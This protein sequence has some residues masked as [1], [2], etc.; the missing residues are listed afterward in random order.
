M[1]QQFIGSLLLLLG[2]GFFAG[3]ALSAA[4]QLGLSELASL[5]LFGAP[6]CVLILAGAAVLVG[7]GRPRT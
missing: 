5:I 1:F 7:T 4:D 2:F 3:W 6:G